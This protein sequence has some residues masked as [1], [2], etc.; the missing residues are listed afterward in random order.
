[1]QLYFIIKLYIYILINNSITHSQVMLENSLV[2]ISSSH[3]E[4]FDLVFEFT[5]LSFLEFSKKQLLQ[6]GSYLSEDPIKQISVSS[7]VLLVKLAFP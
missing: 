3:V 5:N 4:E 7:V 1:L 6:T 2:S